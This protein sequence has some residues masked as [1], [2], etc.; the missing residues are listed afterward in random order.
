MPE[1]LTE[2]FLTAL[3]KPLC[4]TLTVVEL[5]G[6]TLENIINWLLRLDSVQTSQTMSM[7]ALQRAMPTEEEMRFRQDVQ[8]TTCLNP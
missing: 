4:T 2:M 6:K 8:C 1:D 5:T 7:T 3:R